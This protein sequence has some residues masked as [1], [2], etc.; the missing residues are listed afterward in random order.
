MDKGLTRTRR[1]SG[2]MSVSTGHLLGTERLHPLRDCG[3]TLC[4]RGG[5]YLLKENSSLTTETCS[6]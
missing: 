4:R 3:Y 5:G 2:G 1:S 6:A